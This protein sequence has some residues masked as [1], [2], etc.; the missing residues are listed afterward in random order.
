MISSAEQNREAERWETDQ[1]D[2]V[3][4]FTLDA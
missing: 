1:R 4:A 2:P 3:D